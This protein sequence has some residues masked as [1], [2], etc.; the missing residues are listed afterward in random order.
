MQV[1][2]RLKLGQEEFILKVD[3]ANAIEFFEKL[4][5]YSSLPKVGP[6]GETDL[7]ITHRTTPQ[8]YNYYS[9]VSEQAGQEFKFGQPKEDPK[10]LFP[11]GWSPLFRGE[12][13]SQQQS[14]GVGVQPQR[15]AV[16]TQIGRP[17]SIGTAGIPI[18]QP[19]V[20]APPVA[21]PSQIQATQAAPVQAPSPAVQ[22]SANDV[23]ARFGIRTPQQ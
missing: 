5:F 14:A 10:V 17:T 16:T 3:V 21:V 12:E 1:E 13:E 11:K 18:P 23:L 19:T 20:I 6:A 8:G 4:S 7:K 2:Y 9:I 22:K 15:P